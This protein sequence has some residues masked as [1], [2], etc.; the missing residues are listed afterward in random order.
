MMDIIDQESLLINQNVL[1]N[2]NVQ[3]NVQINNEHFVRE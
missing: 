1:N 2:L 3:M